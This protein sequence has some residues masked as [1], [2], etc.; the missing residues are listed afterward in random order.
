MRLNRAMAK[1]TGVAVAKTVP[2][3]CAMVGDVVLSIGYKGEQVR[4]Y[5]KD[6]QRFDLR[7]TYVDEGERLLGTA[8]ALR[9]ASDA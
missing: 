6:G 8:G 5:V 3:S 9:L 2:V 4:S 1:P 7:V